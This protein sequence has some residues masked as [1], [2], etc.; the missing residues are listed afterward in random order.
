MW[1]E[2]PARLRLGWI[3][4]RLYSPASSSTATS[5]R[6][7]KARN[8]VITASDV[9]SPAD[10]IGATC[11][12]RSMPASLLIARDPVGLRSSA[13]IIACGCARGS[14]D[15]RCLLNPDRLLWQVPEP[16]GRLATRIS[17]HFL[18]DNIDG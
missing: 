16:A 5:G 14:D 18:V 6:W 13:S 4:D 9:P 7:P 3:K 8:M 17:E 1:T 10:T 15:K 2:S 11:R 12:T